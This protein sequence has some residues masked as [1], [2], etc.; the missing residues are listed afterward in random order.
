MRGS[1]H[2]EAGTAQ[3]NRLAADPGVIRGLQYTAT[4]R[5]TSRSDL[6][7]EPCDQEGQPDASAH[8]RASSWPLMAGLPWALLG[9]GLQNQNRGSD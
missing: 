5:S 9:T 1:S 7:T 3:L 4:P 2:G 8:R 6:H